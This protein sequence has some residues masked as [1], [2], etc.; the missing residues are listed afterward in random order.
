MH[1][2]DP[3]QW[4]ELSGNDNICKWRWFLKRHL[5]QE[6]G[7]R[8]DLSGRSVLHRCEMH[9]GILSRAVVPRSVRWQWMIYHPYN[10]FLLLPEEHRPYPPNREWALQVAYARYGRVNVIEWF[11][12]LPFRYFPFKLI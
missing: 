7:F 1:P 11:E 2:Y 12:S 6:R 10:C 8:S 4:L 3:R 9:E 5:L